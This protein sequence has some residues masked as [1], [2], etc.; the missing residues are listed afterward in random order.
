MDVHERL[1]EKLG[2]MERLVCE[3]KRS[4]SIVELWPEAF[5]GGGLVAGWH[6]RCTQ[7]KAGHPRR[8]FYVLT[9]KD[10]ERR[11]FGFSDVPDVLQ[12]TAPDIRGARE[13]W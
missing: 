12:E 7:G 9:R 11:E 10:G 4:S 5:K 8:L 3:H 1:I 13:R 6:S 2:E